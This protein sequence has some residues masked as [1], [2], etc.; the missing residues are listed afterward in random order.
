MRLG[1]G[2]MVVGFI[3]GC[4]SPR[5]DRLAYET[6]RRTQVLNEQI[7]LNVMGGTFVSVSQYIGATAAE[8]GP[9]FKVRSESMNP[10]IRIRNRDCQQ[11]LLR[12]EVSNL[13]S[14]VLR[15]ET[16]TIRL[17]ERAVD[18]ASR[19]LLG[20][21]ATT[22]SRQTGEQGTFIVWPKPCE[23]NI[24]DGEH[25]TFSVCLDWYT[26][27]ADV[28]AGFVDYGDCFQAGVRATCVET[29]IDGELSLSTQTMETEVRLAIEP[30]NQI[31]VAAVANLPNDPISI[32]A[33]TEGM[34]AHGADFAIVVGDLTESGSISEAERIST[35]LD[36]QLGIPWFATL[37]DQDVDGNLGLEYLDWFGSAS[38][39]FDFGGIRFVALDSASRGLKETSD[40]LDRWLS[41]QGLDETETQPMR[42][43]VF[44]HYP[45]FTRDGGTDPQF[46][47]ALESGDLVARLKRINALGLVVGQRSWPGKETISSLRMFHVGDSINQEKQSWY[48]FTID[49]A[50]LAECSEPL[51]DCNCFEAL[52][53]TE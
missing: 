32:S 17:G 19:R 15:C 18:E 33:L 3:V 46:D 5:N 8:S 10:V 2:L 31:V 37:G 29:V 14:A 45:P 38:L 21:L 24:T 26:G 47:H 35:L 51:G 4:S 39:A 11:Q 22:N 12:F 6:S 28:R 25:A 52:H 34:S 53:I 48:K 42:H 9:K 44:T 50:C 27:R 36:A 43:L 1:I 40:L 13:P 20:P 7:E 30:S 16:Q 23:T 49:R 41:N